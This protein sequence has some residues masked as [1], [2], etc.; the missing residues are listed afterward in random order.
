M[1]IITGGAGFI[2][3]TVLWELNNAG[4]TE[5]LIVDN[6]AS[7]EKWKNLV[8]HIFI[9]YIHR[10]LFLEKLYAGKF[11]GIK[12]IIHLGACSSTTESNAD[13]LM[14][15]NLHYSMRLCQYAMQHGIRFLNASSASTYGDGSQGFNDSLDTIYALRPLNMYG[16]S[17]HQF[18]LWL[19]RK[20]YHN[21]VASFKFF[22]VYGPNEYHK[23][24][25]RSVVL[26]LFLDVQEGKPTCLFRSYKKE[27]NDGEQA[28]DFIY[29]KDCSKVLFHF[30]MHPEW[31]GIFNL[32]TG[33]ANT[34]N[35]LAHTVHN[36]LNI[37]RDIQY[38]P[39]PDVLQNKYQYYTKAAME[40][41]HS[42]TNNTFSFTSL[43]DGIFDYVQNYLQHDLA[44]L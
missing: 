23:G 42:V 19:L 38:I 10:D 15:N 22:N 40:H 36:A 33:V 43:Q 25:M 6:L 13:F 28:R 32:G 39:M 34:W 3:S 17:K 21:T 1:Y 30:L 44:Y 24:N 18:D 29:S 8:G 11:N 5:I 37:E 9:D 2:G 31:N 7:T 20:Q 41:F 35:T 27:Y 16:F 26:K 12:G 14:E 4:I